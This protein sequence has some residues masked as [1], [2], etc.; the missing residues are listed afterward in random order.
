VALTGWKR[1]QPSMTDPAISKSQ[2]ISVLDNYQLKALIEPE[3]VTSV[4]YGRNASDEDWCRRR[5]IEINLY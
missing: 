2:I 3:I 1:V 5:Q 4:C